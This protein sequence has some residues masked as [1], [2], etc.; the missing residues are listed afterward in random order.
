M[1]GDTAAPGHQAHIIKLLCGILHSMHP[2]LE[3][4]GN[5]V[6]QYFHIRKKLL[7]SEW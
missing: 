4:M 6:G 1:R 3:L 7:G 5:T 2:V